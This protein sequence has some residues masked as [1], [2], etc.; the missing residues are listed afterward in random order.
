MFCP[1]DPRY[2]ARAGPD[3]RRH[4]LR[5]IASVRASSAVL[6]D[7]AD[8]TIALHEASLAST[9]G[10]Y[11]DTHIDD[12]DAHEAALGELGNVLELLIRAL[13]DAD[14]ESE[15]NGHSMDGVSPWVVKAIGPTEFEIWAR[16][17]LLYENGV[18]GSEPLLATIRLTDDGRGISAYDLKSGDPARE[19][20]TRDELRA[21]QRRPE[22]WS[23][24]YVKL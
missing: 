9:L 14:R 3:E 5:G 22:P 19:I 18:Q 20:C 2:S 15:V 23:L 6:D 13:L 21:M 7:N 11:R 12:Y 4:S 10:R 8:V 16:V 24:R 1:I 17:W